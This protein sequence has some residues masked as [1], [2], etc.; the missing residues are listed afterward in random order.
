MKV[1]PLAVLALWTAVGAAQ[2]TSAPPAAA[3]PDPKAAVAAWL[4]QVDGPEQE[5][6]QKQVVKTFEAGLADLRTRYLAAADAATAKASAAGQLEDALAW[7][8]ERQTFDKE[9]NVAA[10][11]SDTPAAIKAL[12]AGFR[13]ELR[14][15]DQQR[16][17]QAKLLLSKYDAVLAKYETLLT[18]RGSLDDALLLK[19]K[20]DEIAKV[21]LAPSPLVTTDAALS[22]A[23][24][25]HEATP[26]AFN[27]PTVVN[28]LGMKFVPIPITGGPSNGQRVLFSIWDTRVQDYEVF[29]KQTRRPW[30][31]SEFSQGPTQ[32]AVN[33]DWDDAEA[34]C[35]WLTER[36]R[37][38]GKL[39]LN[40]CY[41]LPSDHEWSCAVGI[42]EMEDASKPPAEKRGKIDNIF[43][44]GT[45]WPPPDKAGN[46]AS[47]ELK[48]LQAAGKFTSAKTLVPNYRDGYANT[49]PVG[50]YAP[51]RFGLY[52]MGG[53]VLEWCEDWFDKRDRVLRGSGWWH[54]ARN[55]LLS[56]ARDHRT[57]DHKS[58]ERGFRCVLA[59]VAR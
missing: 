13:E 23:V 53:N 9:Q 30:Q 39:G 5:S 15:L 32:P 55:D 48:P 38:E 42:G 17:A 58:D 46:F 14:R 37:K 7:R 45:Q 59:P 20:R 8:T 22:P 24:P 1:S 31:K 29:T 36:E 56:S 19:N 50:T 35:A 12:R 11:A 41:R 2:V 26:S 52:D 25:A 4:Q 6:F 40:E 27:E 18:Q 3:T 47:E 16:T 54:G 44:W 10:D 21:W 33:V 28:S 49:S 57:P 43:P 34:F 51:N